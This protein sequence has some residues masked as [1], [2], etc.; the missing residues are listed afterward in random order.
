MVDNKR[1]YK[2]DLGIKGLIRMKITVIRG[3]ESREFENR[4][5]YAG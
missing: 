4:L 1:N 2:F 3:E 5:P